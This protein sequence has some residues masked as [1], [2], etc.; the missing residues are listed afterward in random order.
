VFQP[1]LLD[2]GPKTHRRFTDRPR[3]QNVL[4]FQA[5]HDSLGLLGD[6]EYVINVAENILLVL[7]AIG[8][9]GRPHP[10]IG[11]CLASLEAGLPES[12]S[13]M[14][15]PPSTA[16][17]QAIQSL[18]NHHGPTLLPLAKLSTRNCVDLLL[19]R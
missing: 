3:L 8:L 14:I 2:F 10:H 1:V 13:E 18:Y 16:R 15:M 11:I 4:G 9:D 6:N 7:G 17:P 19:S 12:S 5:F